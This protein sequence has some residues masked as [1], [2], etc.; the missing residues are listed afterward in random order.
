MAHQIDD[1]RGAAL[2]SRVVKSRTS[3]WLGLLLFAAAPAASAQEPPP[4]MMGWTG[5]AQCKITI[6]APGYSHRETHEWRITGDGTRQRNVGIFPATWTVTGEGTLRR[7]N[8]PTT[9]TAQWT[10]NGTLGT[11]T[12][13]STLHLDRVTIQRWTNHGPARG[14]LTGNEV[15]TTNGVAR[16]RFVVLDV[17]QW[18]FPLVENP[19][20]STR[21]TGSSSLPFD[22]ARGPMAPAG[23]VGA[24][25][26]T[27]DFSRDGSASP[28][29]K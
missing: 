25:A 15:S 2:R 7:V 11:L 22:G 8:G 10:I 23:S 24:S 5:W 17:Q 18:A 13:G 14:G 27:W 20:K 4:A 28:P 19:I 9:T 26:C 6:E 21:M 16:S 12:I 1:S 3:A 29:P